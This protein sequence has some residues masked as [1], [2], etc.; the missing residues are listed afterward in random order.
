MIYF[1]DTEFNGFGGDLISLA[2][3]PA[4]AHHSPL[5]LA[6]QTVPDP[7]PFVA[8]HVLPVLGAGPVP[9][10]WLPSRAAFGPAIA[11]YLPPREVATIV[12]DWPD[13]IRLFCQTLTVGNGNMVRVPPLRF[14]LRTD[15]GPIPPLPGGSPHNALWDALAFRALV[16]SRA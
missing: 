4:D 5:H 11:R 7:Q 14:D 9:P 3:A 16:L 13:D 10:L 12:A 15:F 1:L 6:L 2:L 8:E